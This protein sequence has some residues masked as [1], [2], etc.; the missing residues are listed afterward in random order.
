MLPLVRDGPHL[1]T[2]MLNVESF[3]YPVAAHIGMM[4]EDASL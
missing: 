4:G 3:Q 2:P 1:D